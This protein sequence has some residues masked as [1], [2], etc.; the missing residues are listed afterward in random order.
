MEPSPKMTPAMVLRGMSSRLSEFEQSEILDYKSIYF[1]G[2]DKERKV[3]GSNRRGNNAGYDDDRANYRVVKGDHIGYR[4]E[5][6]GEL[7]SGSFGIVMQA[8][9]HKTG[10]TVALKIIRNKKRF[11]R[12]A[13]IEVDLLKRLRDADANDDAGII[14]LHEWFVF[15]NH[16]CITF[17][18][19]GGDLYGYLKK[20]R[21]RGLPIA[22]IRRI[23]G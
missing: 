21:F 14:H 3:K 17:P 7:G 12:Q 13:K 16:L 6:M 20:R 1:V 5:I 10:R 18:M 11:H 19:L 8:L 9:D 15:R 23:A 4:F 2:R 22:S